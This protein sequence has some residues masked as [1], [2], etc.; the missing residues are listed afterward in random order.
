MKESKEDINQYLTEAMGEY[1]EPKWKVMVEYPTGVVTYVDRVG[2]RG[3][4]EECEKYI[5][6]HKEKNF[7]GRPFNEPEQSKGRVIDFSTWQGFGK[8][9]TWAKQQ[10]W[11]IDFIIHPTQVVGVHSFCNL[12]EPEIFAKAI[13]AYLKEGI[14]V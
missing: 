13:Y 1:K 12:L 9:F 8:L 14:K 10:R 6:R 7:W 11:W 2:F 3:T 5:V 4:K